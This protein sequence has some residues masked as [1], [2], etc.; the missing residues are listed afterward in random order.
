M[1]GRPVFDTLP[2][3][4]MAPL[5]GYLQHIRDTGCLLLEQGDLL[6]PDGTVVYGER[7]FAPFSSETDETGP[8]ID[9]IVGV[10]ISSG[11]VSKAGFRV[12]PPSQVYETLAHR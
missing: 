2:E 11:P 8:V 10:T 9:H 6:R 4:A 7:L 1:S 12:T 3:P 5:R